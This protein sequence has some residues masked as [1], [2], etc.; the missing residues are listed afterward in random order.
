MIDS[1]AAQARDS[2]TARRW[3]GLVDLGRTRQIRFISHANNHTHIYA[4]A[5]IPASPG[6]SSPL[7]AEGWAGSAWVRP[8]GEAGIRA[9]PQA[10]DIEVIY[11]K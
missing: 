5:K 10:Q 9:A 3:I 7:L 1:R 4:K 11:D 8:S 2:K 6:S